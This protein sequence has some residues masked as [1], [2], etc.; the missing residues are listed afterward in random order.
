MITENEKKVLRFLLA[1]ISED[2]SIN[3]ISKKCNLT[4]NGAFK[5]LKKLEER[6]I[7]SPKKVANIRS[8]KINFD[9]PEATKLLELILMPQYKEKRIK[10]RH[11]D[12]KPL[13]EITQLC[14]LFGSYVTK[15]ENPN[16]IDVLF[17]FRKKDYDKYQS[18]LGRIK[19]T[20]PLKLH[21]IIQTKED[22][23]GNIRTDLSKKIIM[24]GEVLWGQEF[25][26]DLIKN[27][28]K[29]KA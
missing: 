14:I 26:V 29:R 9:S 12:L 4:P 10:Y 16:D 24:E 2:Y 5:I 28:A 1:N 17:V 7:V 25:L 15:K 22:L 21:D 6:G 23:N 8:Y 27:V 11:E 13:Q 18:I 3:E 19:M 20:F